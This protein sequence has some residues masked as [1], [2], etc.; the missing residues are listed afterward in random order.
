MAK[1]TR[2]Y[3]L[4]K[5]AEPAKPVKPAKEEAGTEL[6]VMPPSEIEKQRGFAVV[7]PALSTEQALQHFRH[8]QEIKE[9]VLSAID[10][11]PVKGKPYICKSGWR[12]IKTMFN[13][14]EHI[15]ESR[16]DDFGGEIL[17]TYRVRVSAPNGAY[18][19]AEMS[20]SSKEPFGRGKPESAVMAMAQTRAFN[21]A[22]SDLVGGGEV[23]AEEMSEDSPSNGGSSAPAYEAPR[24]SAA[25]AA[26]NPIQPRNPDAPRSEQQAKKLFALIREK[27]LSVEQVK[28]RSAAMFKKDS[29]KTLTMGEMSQLIDYY[30]KFPAKPAQKPEAARVK[31]EQDKIQEAANAAIKTPDDIEVLPPEEED[32]LPY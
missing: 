3:Q 9:Q 11:V 27:G 19:D 18:A 5:G 20:C 13:L 15:L 1:E 12:K 29:T 24:P 6:V 17:Y 7:Q 4:K 30:D 10:K 32:K 28:L 2:K 8:F 16:R 21:R 26:A 23:S 31:S 14:T 25:P 22:I